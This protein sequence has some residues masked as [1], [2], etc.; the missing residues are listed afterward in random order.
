MKNLRIN[1]RPMQTIP[2][3]IKNPRKEITCQPDLG[4]EKGTGDTE[5][6]MKFAV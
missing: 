1:I 3:E 2:R 6:T 5:T 4:G